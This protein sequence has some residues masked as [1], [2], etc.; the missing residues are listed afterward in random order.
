VDR[1]RSLRDHFMYLLAGEGAHAPFDRVIAGWPEA[2]RG[3]IPAGAAHSGWML[4]E[5]LRLAQ[6]DIVEYVR[7]PSHVSPPW[8]EGY[9]PATDEPPDPG[10]WDRAA[11][12][13]GADV[14]TLRGWVD[15]PAVDLL[16]PLPHAPAATVLRE[17]L[18]V[19]DHNAYHLGQMVVVR[20][21]L[22][23]WP[24]G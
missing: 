22:G 9:W 13:F 10:A 4:L 18:L 5:H 23:V 20:R 16:A 11:A 2:Q 12:A 1:D 3:I 21:L 17:V 15:D 14:G 6:S 24:E 8:P 7:S 19:A